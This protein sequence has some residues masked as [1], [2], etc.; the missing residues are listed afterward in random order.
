VGA[1]T[2]GAT[3]V[4]I[5]LGDSGGA[6]GV[7][8]PPAGTGAVAA[9][10]AGKRA[11]QAASRAKVWN[12]TTRNARRLRITRLELPASSPREERGGGFIVTFASGIGR[13][14]TR[15]YPLVI[16][17]YSIYGFSGVCSTLTS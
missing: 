4:P 8:L 14:Q 10:G 9:G 16:A 12:P 2:A 1:T 6:P 15:I 17:V 11:V 3:Q 7:G 5:R 13:W